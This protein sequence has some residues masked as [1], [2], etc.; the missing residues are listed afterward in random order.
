MLYSLVPGTSLLL[1]HLMKKTESLSN[2]HRTVRI[3]TALAAALVAFAALATAARHHHA[4]TDRGGQAGR[5]DYYVLSLSW[6]PTYCRTHAD[7]GEECSGRGYG[8]V[9]HGLWP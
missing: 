7:D 1:S 4:P 8:F 5:F 6:A 2:R 9:L 3:H